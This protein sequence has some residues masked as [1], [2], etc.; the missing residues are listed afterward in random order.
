MATLSI[1]EEQA[2]EVSTLRNAIDEAN[3]RIRRLT[4]RKNSLEAEFANIEQQLVKTHTE[5]SEAIERFRT[6][7]ESMPKALQ[8]LAGSVNVPPPNTTTDR[9]TSEQKVGWVV[10]FL[11][12]RGGKTTLTILN[13]A[14]ADAT[15][16]Q[17]G[18]LKTLLG[19]NTK[20][21]RIR[22]EGKLQTVSLVGFKNEE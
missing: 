18:P 19:E 21:F 16:K 1:T 6:T 8:I 17:P 20:T 2:A 14:F 11:K 5:A 15:G 4:D 10:S 9:M 3:N 22:G 13:K 12:D 7:L